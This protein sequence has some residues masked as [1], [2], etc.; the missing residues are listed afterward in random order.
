MENQTETANWEPKKPTVLDESKLFQQRER[1]RLEQNLPMGFA[2]GVIAALLGAIVWA[3]VTVTTG[4]QI[5]YM[6][7]GIGLLVGF[8]VRFLGKGM[9]QIF[10]IMGAV[11]ALAGCL[12]GNF[13]SI[14]GYVGQSEDVG[15]L[16]LLTEID[17]G[18]VPDIMI[19]AFSPMDILFYGIAVYEGY[20]FS[21]RQLTE[22]E[23]A[24]NA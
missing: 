12:I 19:E 7:V 17:Y 24:A 16:Q 3:V 6:A 15:Y 5:G 14:I 4:Y 13:F 8:S 20:K 10:G 11:L 21:F 18:L 23:L 9:D 2:G 1:L 22:N